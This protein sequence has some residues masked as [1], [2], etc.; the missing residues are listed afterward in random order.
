MDGEC[1]K[2]IRPSLAKGYARTT[3]LKNMWGNHGTMATKVKL[4]RPIGVLIWMW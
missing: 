4:L 1:N 2:A 3:Q